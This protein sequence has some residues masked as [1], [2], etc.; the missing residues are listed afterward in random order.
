MGGGASKAAAEAEAEALREAE[1]RAR[2]PKVCTTGELKWALAGKEPEIELMAGSKFVLQTKAAVDRAKAEAARADAEASAALAE[3]ERKSA[4]ETRASMLREVGRELEECKAVAERCRATLEELTEPHADPGGELRIERSVRLM[5]SG[6][7]DRSP[8]GGISHGPRIVGGVKD[9][10]LVHRSKIKLSVMECR[11]LRRMDAFGKNDVY[12]VLEL[13]VEKQ[14]TTTVE[15]TDKVGSNPKWGNGYGESKIFDRSVRP[16]QR[17]SVRLTVWDEDPGPDPDDLIGSYVVEFPLSVEEAKRRPH[18]GSS[19]FPFSKIEGQNWRCS[20]W[21]PLTD[22]QD[23]PAGEINLKILWT[24]AFAAAV[25]EDAKAEEEKEKKELT[26]EEKKALKQAEAEVHMPVLVDVST[27]GIN[28]VMEGLEI[29][30]AHN[31]ETVQV[32]G[33]SLTAEHCEIHGCVRANGP[34][35]SVTLKDCVIQGSHHPGVGCFGGATAELVGG[36]VEQCGRGVV[37]SGSG[38]H[39]A[40]A[41]VLHSSATVSGTAVCGNRECGVIAVGKGVSIALKDGADKASKDNG[42]LHLKNIP[43]AAGPLLP[44][45]GHEKPGDMSTELTAVDF[46]ELGGGK[47]SG[48]PSKRVYQSEGEMSTLSDWHVY[49]G[50]TEKEMKAKQLAERP[51]GMAAEVKEMIREHDAMVMARKT[52]E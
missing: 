50:M 32:W 7:G 40:T 8:G 3:A 45:D 31:V 28:V 4:A 24:D 18:F 38:R 33:G 36:S 46:W 19:A 39:L 13:G 42:Q 20:D 10:G 16:N 43:G 21:F 29:V 44:K 49:V 48:A 14:R 5:A 22:G 2:R 30:S 35:A 27:A 12:V 25:D 47:I 51:S 17:T 11:G 15:G 52:A 37:A 41:K 9:G 6:G 26:R 34:T 23:R 1:R